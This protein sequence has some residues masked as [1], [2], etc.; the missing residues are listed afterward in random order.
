[1][2]AEPAYNDDFDD[3]NTD[4]TVDMPP[5]MA[6]GKSVLPNNVLGITPD[7]APLEVPDYEPDEPA[8]VDGPQDAEDQPET[9]E[10]PQDTADDSNTTTDE[11]D[12]MDAPD[13]ADADTTAADP[14]D[15]E[16]P[17][18]PF[19]DPTTH[20]AAAKAI[21]ADEDAQF[22]DR[23][24]SLRNIRDY[25]DNGYASPWGVL[26]CCMVFALHDVPHTVALPRIGRVGS[27]G[28]LN[29]FGAIVA[30]PGGGKGQATGVGADFM[31]HNRDQDVPIGTGEG[32]VKQFMRPITPTR[33][34]QIKKDG[35]IIDSYVNGSDTYEWAR[36][37]VN[38]DASEV[39]TLE[40]LAERGG[41]TLDEVSRK[42]GPANNSDSESPP[43]TNASSSPATPIASRCLSESSPN[44]AASSS[45]T[46][47][48][49]GAHRTASSSPRPATN[50]ASKPSASRP[51]RRRFRPDSTAASSTTSEAPGPHPGPTSSP[52]PPTSKKKSS[53][54]SSA[55]S[56]STATAHKP[57]KRSPLRWPS[58]TVADT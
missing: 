37:A 30:E 12:A 21:Y 15:P 57:A 4:S 6:E 5:W 2:T 41:A 46:T 29:F 44:A 19:T 13:N 58:S 8:P 34:A 43:T 35:L 39:G 51:A 27:P 9:D 50:A 32:L 17:A 55:V 7:P 54:P 40:K 53:T 18:T 1:M 45:P 42:D 49:Q 38:L 31:G 24:Q 10:G 25:A 14:E 48:A 26:L 33:A 3:E 36:R 20:T 11:A 52:Y 23:R 56:A 22:W 16:D 47:P 28:S